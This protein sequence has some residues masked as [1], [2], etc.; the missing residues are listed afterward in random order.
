VEHRRH[1]LSL[2]RHQHRRDIYTPAMW[3]EKNNFFIVAPHLFDDFQALPVN[4][5]FESSPG[6]VLLIQPS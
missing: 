4:P 5:V 6:H 2:G 3:N 1:F